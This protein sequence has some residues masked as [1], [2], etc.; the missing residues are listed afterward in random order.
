MRLPPWAVSRERSS[1]SSRSA[2]SSAVSRLASSHRSSCCSSSLRK[3]SR[4][5]ANAGLASSRLVRS[6]LV[7]TAVG[8]P[9]RLASGDRPGPVAGVGSHPM[10]P[11]FPGKNLGRELPVRRTSA[12]G[13]HIRKTGSGC[14]AP[15]RS[16]G[17]FDRQTATE[18]EGGV[19]A[20]RGGSDRLGTSTGALM[21][22][23]LFHVAAFTPRAFAGHPA[24]VCLCPE[25]PEPG[26]M[27]Q[28][29][30]AMNLSE[31]SFVVARAD[32]FDLR[33]FT[34]TGEVDLCGH[35]TLAA[36]HTLW[37]SGRLAAGSRARFHTLSGVLTA[38]KAGDWIELDFPATPVATVTTVPPALVAGLGVRALS[39]GKSRFDFVVEVATAAEVSEARPDLAA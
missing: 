14:L 29:A 34:P 11:R 18:S 25:A 26:W 30:A 1:I 5:E 37:E 3:L 6:A 21:P 38:A 28:V 2:W 12:R 17:E 24:A 36:A 33:W 16:R 9:K 15:R 32:G 8:L 20:L 31:T 7:G 10:S 22:I 23:D 39:I 27:Q 35:A 4:R 13:E 19:W